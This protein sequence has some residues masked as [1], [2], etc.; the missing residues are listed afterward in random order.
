MRRVGFVLLALAPGIALANSG[1]GYFMVAVPLVAIALL[2][3]IFLEAPV[4]WWRLKIPWRKALWLSFVAN[5]LSTLYG[6]ILG[7]AFDFIVAAGTQT[8]GFPPSRGGAAV[9]LVPWFFLSWWIEHKLVAKRMPEVPRPTV[10]RA[11]AYANLLTYILMMVAALASPLYPERDPTL[12][13][14]R[15]SEAVLTTSPLREAI[16]EFWK[17]QKRFPRD[18]RE[19]NFTPTT[20]ERFT[21][22]LEK[23]GRIVVR[24]AGTGDPA[25]D[26][27][28]IEMTPR[29]DSASSLAWDCSS[30]DIEQK[31]LPALA[32]TACG[33]ARGSGRRRPSC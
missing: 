13:R 2:P 30:P 25:I 27:K 17:A 24:I 11:T 28:R 15:I 10:R 33:T 4:L 7:I 29:A 23:E 3:A 18:L 22:S 6:F 32:A 9:M 21:F 31:Y 19:L 16:A 5:A 1:I 12:S 14:A 20:G 26:G 8:S